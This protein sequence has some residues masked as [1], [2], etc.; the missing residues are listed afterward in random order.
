M[1]RATAGSIRCGSLPANT[2]VCIDS[3]SLMADW[4]VVDGT[5]SRVRVDK[6][7]SHFIEP[8]FFGRHSD[9][10]SRCNPLRLVTSHPLFSRPPRP[11]FTITPAAP[12]SPAAHDPPAPPLSV[13]RRDQRMMTRSFSA[14]PISSPHARD[15]RE[16]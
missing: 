6:D 3:E 14:F 2:T 13:N 16:L 10:R 1:P 15:E 4:V 11:V 7:A 9:V 8:F 12:S 5:R